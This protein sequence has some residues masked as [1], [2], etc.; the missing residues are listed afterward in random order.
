MV[1]K[2]AI[3]LFQTKVFK[4]A[5]VAFLTGLV[6]ILIRC[7]YER[8]GMTLEDCLT[9]V[10]LSSTLATTVIGRMDTSPVYTPDSLP[11]ANKSDFQ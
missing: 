8:R 5:L 2:R 10:A 11:G 6:P 9:V 1:R 7:G 3:N 4:S